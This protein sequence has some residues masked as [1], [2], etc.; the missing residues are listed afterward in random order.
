MIYDAV[1]FVGVCL[2]G[3]GAAFYDW[4]AALIIF[5]ALLLALAL[6]GARIN[7]AG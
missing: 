6:N 3:L 4:R 5:G 7:R 2:I 1:A